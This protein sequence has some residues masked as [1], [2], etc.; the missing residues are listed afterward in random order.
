MRRLQIAA[1]KLQAAEGEP[2]PAARPRFLWTAGEVSGALGDL[3]TF[4]PHI[5]GA[6]TIVKMDP[7]GILTSFGMFYVFSGVF[8]GVPMAVQ[9]MKA[10]SAVVLI[11]PMNPAAVAGAGLVIGAFFLILGLSG[12]V[13]RLARA[14]PGSIA[15]GLQLGLGLSLGVLGLRLIETQL[16]L[17]AAISAAM[18]ALLRYE[19]LPAA[20]IAVAAGIG[21]GQA[22]GLA[23]PFPKLDFGLHLPPLVIPSW[24]QIAHG[25]EYAVLPQ[26]PLTLTNAII[27]TAAVTRQL[28]PRELH[29]VNER[30]LAITTGLGNLLAA[31]FGGYPMCHGAGGIA[32]HVRFGARSATAPV[33]I[34]LAFLGLGAALGNSG[35]ALLRTIPDAVLGSLLLFSGLE[36]AL[37]SKIS[38]YRRGDLFL[39]L[40]MAAICVA[41][42]PAAAFAVGLPIAYAL[43][44]GWIRI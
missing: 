33:L 9:P 4:L 2:A 19:R 7:T 37:S 41:L 21:L 6:I 40:L 5:I 20:L 24:A 18:L 10:A 42:N 26:I 22:L 11:E 13:G 28:F 38:E 25:T 29:P 30:N 39:V 43:E 23:P 8:Y 16:W 34:G 44:R 31:P 36:L 14:L 12:V 1:I 27:V 15:A 32:G 17:G 3:G 35:Y